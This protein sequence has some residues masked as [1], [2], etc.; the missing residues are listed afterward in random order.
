[1]LVYLV[2]CAVGVEGVEVALM[3]REKSGR[4]VETWDWS[5]GLKVHSY[6][7]L[8]HCIVDVVGYVIPNIACMETFVRMEMS[9]CEEVQKGKGSLE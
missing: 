8:E 5:A 9:R 1:M 6:L 4:F 3:E 2:M 7:T